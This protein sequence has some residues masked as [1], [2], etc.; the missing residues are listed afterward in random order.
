MNS[1][2]TSVFTLSDSHSPFFLSSPN[3]LPVCLQETKSQDDEEDIE[4]DKLT[5]K[6]WEPNYAWTH[7]LW[8][9]KHISILYIK[10][11]YYQTVNLWRR[12]NYGNYLIVRNLLK[13][14]WDS[15]RFLAFI[16]RF[17]GLELWIS[18]SIPPRHSK[19]T[20]FA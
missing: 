10:I 13:L 7:N 20:Y 14:S 6:F 15:P 9:H 8:S 12:K 4:C 1:Q 18:Q 2:E 19:N 3:C 17:I 11:P 16:P 5:D